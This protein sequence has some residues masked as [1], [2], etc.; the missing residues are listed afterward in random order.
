[1]TKRYLGYIRRHWWFFVLGPMFVIFSALSEL[2]LPT[3]TADII[4]VGIANRDIAYI[5]EK[6]LIMVII[7]VLTMICSVLGAC[8]AVGGGAHFAADLRKD[9]FD[10]VEEYSFANLDDLTTGSLITRITNDVGQIQTTVQQMMRM[11]LRSPVMMVGA[12]VMS[13]LL[14]PRLASVLCIIVPL[15]AL[16]IFLLVRIS[17]PRYTHM[18]E[19]LDALNTRIGESIENERVIKSFVREAYEEEKFTLVNHR[20]RERSMRALGLMLWLQPVSAIAIN[21]GTLA[22]V[23]IAG[24][25]IMI[26]D[27]EIGTLTAFITYLSQ[28]LT[29][30]NVFAN[31]FLNLSR[32]AASQR[33]ICQIFDEVLDMTDESAQHPHKQVTE[34]AVE[35]R[36]VSFRYFKDRP[37]AVISNISFSVAPGETVG[38]IGSTGSG[39]STLVSLI[40]RLYDADEGEVLIDGVNVRDYSFE[41]LRSGISVVLQKNTLFSGTVRENLYWGWENATDEE[42]KNACDIAQASEFISQFKAGYDTELGQGG[43]TLSGGQR[44][45][46]CIATALLKKPKILILDD[47]TSALDTA[48]DAKFRRALRESMKNT[49]CLVIAQRITSVIDADRILVLDNGRLVGNGRHEELIHTCRVYREIYQTQREGDGAQ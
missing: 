48:T 21:V 40:P 36:N 47:S 9:I 41:N 32:A 42:L 2:L 4:N 23:W 46:L 27:M 37:E 33:R 35:M 15:L 30:L 24:G 28:V 16:S 10:R 39:K 3:I 45:R 18:Q 34:G 1:M 7:S 25:Q 43:I 20:L 49:T 22:A 44:Q 31:F 29:S 11:S 17:M 8:F 38:I 12:I 19:Q 5:W 13:F 6:G 14:S 26:G